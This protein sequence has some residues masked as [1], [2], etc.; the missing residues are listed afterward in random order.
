MY[1]N[2]KRERDGNLAEAHLFLEEMR[3]R[4]RKDEEADDVG[5]NTYSSASVV[6]GGVSEVGYRLLRRI[7]WDA[8]HAL[9]RDG[10]LPINEP[11][12]VARLHFTYI[13]TYICTH[14]YTLLW[15]SVHIFV[16]R[17]IKIC[18][19]SI[20]YAKERHTERV[21]RSRDSF[22]FLHPRR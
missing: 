11:I 18:C 2:L 7:G 22:C 8:Q 5:S 13:Y 17:Y 9:G 3:K 19:G 15:T 1:D 16:L 10:T 12:E 20:R 14:I 21:T 4:I 6:S